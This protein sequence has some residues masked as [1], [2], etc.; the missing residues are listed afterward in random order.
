[1][2]VVPA[3]LLRVQSSARWGLATVRGQSMMPLLRPGDRLLV[4]Y[5]RPPRTGDVVV[6]R[7]SDGV[8]AVK[9]AQE[10]A[11]HHSGEDGWLLTSDNLAAPG[12][13]RAPVPGSA[14]LG[15]V[16]LRVWP[17]PRVLRRG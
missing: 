4:D 13:R 12:A 14:V 17:R 11:R 2:K 10:P 9:R 1:M 5:R 6:A 3:T 15:I 7:F 8:L 16:V